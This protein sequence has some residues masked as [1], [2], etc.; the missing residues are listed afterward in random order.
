MTWR[1]LEAEKLYGLRNR[2]V[3][4]VRSPCEFEA[5]RIPHA[6]N[7]PLLS[8]SEREEVGIVYARD[9]EVVA[10]RLGLTIISPKIPAIVDRIC[11]L[12]KQ[13]APLVIHCWRGGLRSEAVA[14][15][16]A[17]VGIDCWRL[18]GGYKAWRRLVL[19]DFAR[20]EFAGLKNFVVLQGRT[21]VGKTEILEALERRGAQVLNL[22]KLA[23]HR[24]SFFGGLGLSAQPTQKNFE[25]ELWEKI[26][27][28]NDTPVFVEAE[29]RK[30]GRISLPDWVL[31]GIANGRQVLITDSTANRRQRLLRQYLPFT[32]GAH[33][34]EL[35]GRDENQAAEALKHISLLANRLGK[36]NIARILE[37]S[38]AK[39]YGEIVEILLELY[40]DPLYDKGIRLQRRFHLTVI[41]EDSAEAAEE[42]WNWSQRL[43]TTG[44]LQ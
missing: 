7:V 31:N 18:K 10:R 35:G 15:F 32:T 1:E 14:S 5:E 28:M 36:Q 27:S 37:L 40:Y 3:V 4:D 34:D 2:I 22:E 41:G 39:D 6:I 20:A 25:G 29:S 26:V 23:S 44:R 19:N 33:G 21:G 13:D 30:V 12:K 17:I 9:G 38:A 11:R 43:V 16:L 8:D 24:G 42:I